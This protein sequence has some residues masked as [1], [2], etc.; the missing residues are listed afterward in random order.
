MDTNNKKAT[1]YE[2]FGHR[3]TK[4]RKQHGMNRSEFARACGVAGASMQNYETGRRMPQGDILQS[5]AKVLSVSI[6]SLMDPDEMESNRLVEECGQIIDEALS[7]RQRARLKRSMEEADDILSASDLSLIDKQ[8]YILSMQRMLLDAMEQTTITY[9][10]D[11][12]AQKRKAEFEASRR[13]LDVLW[14]E[15]MSQSNCMAPVQH[16]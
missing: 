11:D 1:P 12:V 14:D 13:R 15:S 10:R 6:D 9:S 5:M 4:L 16:Q 2:D 7:K 8:A 3:L